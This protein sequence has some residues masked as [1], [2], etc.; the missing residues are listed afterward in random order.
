[1]SAVLTDEDGAPLLSDA[2]FLLYDET[3]PQSEL[4]N[5]SRTPKYSVDL[6]TGFERVGVAEAFTLAA[7]VGHLRPGYWVLSGRPSGL[8]APD[9][10]AVDSII[11]Y[12]DN[13]IR[14]AGIVRTVPDVDGR[15]ERSIDASGTEITWTGTDLF[16][17]LGTR[18][19]WPDPTSEPPWVSV[20]H[21]SRTG[22]ASTVAAGFIEANIGVSAIAARTIDALTCIDPVIGTTGTWTKRL[23]SLSTTVASV[24]REGQ[25]SVV[26]SMPSPGEI[27]F[28][29]RSV[30]DLRNQFVFSD[31]G[32]LQSAK[33]VISEATGTIV[34]AA[35]EGQ[36]TAR[37]FAVADS[38]ATGID[39][40]ETVYENTNITDTSTLGL[41]A[42][43]EL[44]RHDDVVTVDAVIAEAALQIIRYGVDYQV[45]DILGVEIGGVRHGSP[46][47]SVLFELTPSRS[48][49]RPILGHAST[50]DLSAL[51]SSLTQVEQHLDRSIS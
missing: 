6:C 45:G 26:A 34:I 51:L 38:G 8:S 25:I 16:G 31:Q 11:V 1:M 35:G 47:T 39:R 49:V 14:Y 28:T 19:C 10:D 29:F 50:S 7:S 37:A 18:Q 9:L 36:G 15:Y 42:A 27:L 13:E 44:A 23:E 12:E 33:R 5:T 21:D 43:A 4:S 32:D 3:W 48:R 20:S 17:L 30:S 24:C 2:G 46:V 22:P 40:V 41:A